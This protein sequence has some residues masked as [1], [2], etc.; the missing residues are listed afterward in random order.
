VR[1]DGLNDASGSHLSGPEEG[2]GGGGLNDTPG[3]CLSAWWWFLA[4]I[5]TP[6]STTPDAC[7][8]PALPP[9]LSCPPLQTP[10]SV[11]LVSFPGAPSLP[12]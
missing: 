5:C 2:H 9:R 8:A 4:R 11:A 6:A 1:E 12:A 7:A 10:S 3:S